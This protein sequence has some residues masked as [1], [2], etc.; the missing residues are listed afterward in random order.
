MLL[1]Q[2]EEGLSVLIEAMTLLDK[3]AERFWEAELFRQKGELL[4]AQSKE[5]YKEAE[6]CFKE[7]VGVAQKQQAK[8]LELRAAMSM[9][10]LWQ[11]QG[12][13]EE[14]RKLLSDIYCWF[15]EGFDTPDLK[16]A[17]ALLDEL[18]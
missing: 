9:C 16:D 3:T 5:N 13:G 15:T 18:S 6:S 1:G 8:S 12:E 14:A 11:S 10:R 2:I 4:L 7:A 17:K